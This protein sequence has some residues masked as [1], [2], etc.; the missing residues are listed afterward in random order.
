MRKPERSH[1]RRRKS[2]RE[3]E[4]AHTTRKDSRVV[5]EMQKFKFK[6]DEAKDGRNEEVE[7]ES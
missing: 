1:G 3:R 4:K 7:G 6:G 5:L 2:F